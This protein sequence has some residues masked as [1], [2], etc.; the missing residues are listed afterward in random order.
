MT[1]LEALDRDIS[2]LKELLR[3]AWKHLADSSLTPF[4]RRE[5]RNQIRHSSAQLRSCLEML[6]A[7]R[8]GSRKRSMEEHADRPNFEKPKLRFLGGGL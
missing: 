6:E 3:V 5:L 1:E 4:E 8:S 7:E 2:A